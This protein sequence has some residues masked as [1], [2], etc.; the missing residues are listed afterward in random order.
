ML[1]GGDP[2][3]LN[4][5]VTPENMNQL[6]PSIARTAGY[7]DLSHGIRDSKMKVQMVPVL[8]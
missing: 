3:D 1:L 2:G 8:S 7:S 5:R 4:L 6:N